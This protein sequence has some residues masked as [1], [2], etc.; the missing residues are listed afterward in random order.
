VKNVIVTYSSIRVFQQCPRQYYWKHVAGI[1]PTKPPLEFELAEKISIG[2]LFHEAI[3][4]KDDIP[5]E[6][7]SHAKVRGMVDAY[8]TVWSNPDEF[9]PPG[10]FLTY[11]V[12][13]YEVQLAYFDSELGVILAGVLDATGKLDDDAPVLIETKTVSSL[14]PEYWQRWEA[15]AQ[16]SMYTLLATQCALDITTAVVDV[17][18]RPA[19]RFNADKEDLESFAKR[20]KYVMLDNP[21]NYFGRHL[22]FRNKRL[23]L[24]FKDDLKSIIEMIKSCINRAEER[25]YKYEAFPTGFASCTEYNKCP[26]KPLCLKLIAEKE[27]EKTSLHPELSFPLRL[28]LTRAELPSGIEQWLRVLPPELKDN[29][30]FDLLME[31]KEPKAR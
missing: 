19:H 4:S 23:L 5:L 9:F 26:F 8:R 16:I 31:F 3:A 14:T 29:A 13:E 15:D 22:V 21:S 24:G 30:V 27:C 18:R 12:D 10:E 28:T 1:D 2:K 17:V 20:I 11:T 25:L 7:D 6:T